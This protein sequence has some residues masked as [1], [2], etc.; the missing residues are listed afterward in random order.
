MSRNKWIDVQ[1]VN[2]MVEKGIVTLSGTLVNW[3]AYRGV[4]NAA[5]YTPGVVDI[6]NN[7]K[8]E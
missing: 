7:L 3:A 8:Y 4:L 5:Q 1:K 2:V 6:I